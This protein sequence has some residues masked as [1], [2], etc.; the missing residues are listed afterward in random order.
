MRYV[1]HST[2][3]GPP[4]DRA[5]STARFVAAYTART[6][7]PSART[8]SNPYA[9]AF[10]ANV[11][12]AVWRLKGTEIAHWLFLHRKTHGTWNTPAKF[13]PTWKSPW[14]VAPS[15]KYVRDTVRSPRIRMAHAVPTA[16]WIC[17]PTGLDGLTKLTSRFP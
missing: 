9:V 3:V 14:L 7:F 2:R 8:P 4:P 15:P 6:S 1:R 12:D 13:I 11:F 16:I 5:R 10:S 17:V